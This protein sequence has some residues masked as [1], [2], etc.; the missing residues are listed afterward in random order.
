[1]SAGKPL[2]AAQR[3]ALEIL[4]S[5]NS[6]S[7]GPGHNGLHGAS[8]SALAAL[9]R[10][11]FCTLDFSALLSSTRYEITPAGRAALAGFK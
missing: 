6:I 5:Y 2:T 4:S 8:G 3:K 9:V 7:T 11:G 10:R 1:M